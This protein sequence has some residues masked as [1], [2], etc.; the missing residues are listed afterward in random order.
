MKP[1]HSRLT[2]TFI[3]AIQE[4]A[5]RELEDSTDPATVAFHVQLAFNDYLDLYRVDGETVA[6]E[7]SRYYREC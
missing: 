5:R 3:A 7:V 1:N 4:W 6:A 2:A